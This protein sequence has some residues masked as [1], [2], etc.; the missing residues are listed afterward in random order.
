MNEIL[1]KRILNILLINATILGSMW[2]MFVINNIFF[3]GA[4]SYGVLPRVVEIGQLF[5]IAFNWI[6]HGNYQHILG[7]T[8]VLIT[9]LPVIALMEEKP[10][11]VIFSLT[12]LDGFFTWVFGASNTNHIGAS[13]LAFALIGYIISAA[14]IGKAWRYLIPLFLSLGNYW[15]VISNG[16]IPQSGVSF[17]GHFGGFVVGLIFGWLYNS[18]TNQIKNLK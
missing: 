10:M 16:L 12:I 4:L 5:G 1:K 8:L 2:I 7:N 11:I 14:T 15:L 3:R 18:E 13:G 9:L 6:F 17:A